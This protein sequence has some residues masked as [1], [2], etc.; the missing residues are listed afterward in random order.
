MLSALVVV[1]LLLARGAHATD[2]GES[3]C[4]CSTKTQQVA[5]F[6]LQVPISQHQAV[7]QECDA[8]GGVLLCF[9]EA[10]AHTKQAMLTCE[11]MLAEESI[12]CPAPAGAP[13]LDRWGLAGLAALLVGLGTLAVRRARA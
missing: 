7:E 5:L 6:C 4:A 11:Q 9:K 3:C 13:T 8:R 2:G 10:D 12:D 1:A